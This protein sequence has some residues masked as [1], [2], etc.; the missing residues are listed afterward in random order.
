MSNANKAAIETGTR[1]PAIF[2]E[3]GLVSA[4]VTS[5]E[6]RIRV[7]IE[8]VANGIAAFRREFTTDLPE[9]RFYPAA[10]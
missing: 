9:Q 1:V 10:A 2:A 5:A 6:S 3:L 8:T 7:G 4:E